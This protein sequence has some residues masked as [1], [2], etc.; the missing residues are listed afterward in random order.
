MVGVTRLL[1]PGAVIE[2]PR[3]ALRSATS[4]DIEP[5]TW[6]EAALGPEAERADLQRAVEGGRAALISRAGEP[7]GVAVAEPGSPTKASASVPFIAVTPAARFRG[8]GGEAGL[9]LDRHLRSTGYSRVFA[10]V[11]EGRGLAVYFWLR[12]GF[13]PLV[14]AEAPGP[15]RGLSGR[16]MPGIWLLRDSD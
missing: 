6:L 10:P 3:L 13:R 15:V 8:L 11:P 7:V 12:L 1:A 2:T 4:A 5:M 16:E 9:A 14:A